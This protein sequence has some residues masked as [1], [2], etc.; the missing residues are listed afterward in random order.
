ME[1]V[2]KMILFTILLIV[3]IAI[4]IAVAVFAIVGA[5]SVAIVFGDFI[6]FGLIV[7]LI[8]KAFKSKK[9]KAQ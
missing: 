2:I 7:W 1:G 3:L 4:A 9:G 8:V 5:G 6:A